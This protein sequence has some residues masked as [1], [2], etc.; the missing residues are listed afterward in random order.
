MCGEGNP[1]ENHCKKRNGGRQRL[2]KGEKLKGMKNA[3][4]IKT[5]REIKIKKEAGQQQTHNSVF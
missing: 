1:G 3:L 5:E 2:A 4:V